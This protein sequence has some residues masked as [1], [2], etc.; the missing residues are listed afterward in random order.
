MQY[1]SIHC[2]FMEQSNTHVR[3]AKEVILTYRSRIKDLDKVSEDCSLT[4]NSVAG[5][6]DTPLVQDLSCLG[7]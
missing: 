1:F 4:N 5:C 3:H 2:V 6:L 7:G